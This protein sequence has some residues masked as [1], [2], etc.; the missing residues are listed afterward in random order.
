MSN[1]LLIVIIFS[2]LLVQ[3]SLAQKVSISLGGG[4]HFTTSNN[5]NLPYWENGYIVGL[6]ADHNLSDRFNLFIS[7]SYQ[8]SFF[9]ENLLRLAVPAVVGYRYNINAENSSVYEISIG[10][11]FHTFNSSILKPFFGLGIGALIIMQGKI[12]MTDWIEG[13]SGKTTSIYGNTGQNFNEGQVNFG[14]GTE[15][16]P[17]NNFVIILDA[18]FVQS[19]S[20]LSYI[21]ITSSIKIGL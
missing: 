1:K 5:S 12:E 8:K 14:V 9:N 20:G 19:F 4:Y 15:I 7:G 10:G 3:G 17:V 13:S 18:K 11:R 2:A 16:Q 21:P 6:T